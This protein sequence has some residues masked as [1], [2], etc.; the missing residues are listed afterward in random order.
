MTRRARGSLINDSGKQTPT[1][2]RLL[3]VSTWEFL[4]RVIFCCRRASNRALRCTSSLED[5][6]GGKCDWIKICANVNQHEREKNGKVDERN[7]PQ[8]I[9][10]IYKLDACMPLLEGWWGESSGKRHSRLFLM[11]WRCRRGNDE[12]GRRLI[13]FRVELD[14]SPSLVS[15][16]S[17]CPWLHVYFCCWRLSIWNK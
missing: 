16:F 8:T 15:L 5:T 3:Q 9:H 13:T 6:E 12:V 10:S 17:I 1:R 4:D 7:Q 14:F 2:S 11:L